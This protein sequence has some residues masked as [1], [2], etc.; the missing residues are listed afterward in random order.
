MLTEGTTAPPAVAA[1][2]D[3]E[4]EA[5]RQVIAQLATLLNQRYV[6]PETAL[7][8]DQAIRARAAR[9]EYTAWP[10]QR[11]SRLR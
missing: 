7:E 1:V 2:S 11:R 6:F 8:M 5:R 4:A 9:G 10:I 3:S